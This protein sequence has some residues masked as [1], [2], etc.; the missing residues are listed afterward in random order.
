[1][2]FPIATTNAAQGTSY[3]QNA[4]VIVDTNGVASV[5]WSDGANAHLSYASPPYSTWQEDA[6]QNG[7]TSALSST[8]S[9]GGFIVRGAT[10]PSTGIVYD[11]YLNLAHHS[12]A[13]I[14]ASTSYTSATQTVLLF[15]DIQ[16][17]DWAVCTDPT[18]TSVEVYETTTPVTPNW[19]SSFSASGVYALTSPVAAICGNYLVVAYQTAAATFTSV[20]I[21]VSPSSL[22]SWS[23]PATFTLAAATASSTFC[24]RGNPSGKGMFVYSS[25]NG[26]AALT[27]D[28]VANTWGTETALSSNGNDTQP[29]LATVGSNFYAVWCRY[30]GANNYA[31]DFNL[32]RGA[33]Q[34][35]DIN[36][37]NLVPE[38]ANNQ[39]PQVGYGAN[40]IGV[41]YTVGTAAPYSVN[42][43]I[44]AA[45]GGL[46]PLSLYDISFASTTL[47]TAYTFATQTGGSVTGTTITSAPASG[48][49]LYMEALSQ[50]GTGTTNASIPAPS[51]KGWL[52]DAT[53][54]ENKN[55]PAGNWSASVTVENGSRSQ[56]LASM[57]IRFSV[58]SSAGA[59]TT[60]GTIAI[61][62][63]LVPHSLQ[64]FSFPA[65]AMP[66]TAFGIGDKL[67]VDYFYQSGTGT[68]AWASDAMAMAMSSLSSFGIANDLQIITPGYESDPPLTVYGSSVAATIITTADQLATTTGG[69]ETSTTTTAPASGAS[70]YME[71]LS[72]GGTGTTSATMPAQSG[73][74]WLLQTTTLDEQKMLAGNWSATVAVSDATR[75]LTLASMVLRFSKHF[76]TG[77]YATIGTITISS[78]ALTTSRQVFTFPSTAFLAS[79]FGIG[80]ML[81]IDFFYQSSGSAGWASDAMAI[82]LSTSATAGV[83]SDLQ[84]ATPGYIDPPGLTV[85]TNAISTSTSAVA[86]AIGNNTLATI[87]SDGTALT[88]WFDGTNQKYSY[89]SSPYSS[90][91]TNTLTTGARFAASLMPDGAGGNVAG[92]TCLTTGPITYFPLTKSGATYTLG[93]GTQVSSGTATFNPG[94]PMMVNKDPQ[95]RYWATCN[96]NADTVAQNFQSSTPTTANWTAGL[97]ATVGNDVFMPVA[98]IV[99]NYL[100]VAYWSSGTIFQYQ[101]LDVSQASLGSWST[102]TTIPNLGTTPTDDNTKQHAFRGNGS[103]VGQLIAASYSGIYAFGYTAATDT[104]ASGVQL[105]TSSS[106]LYPTIIGDGLGNLYCIWCLFS[107]TNS[108]SLVYKKWTGSTNTWDSSATTLIAA[109]TNIANPNAGWGNNGL[110]IL[111]TV[112]TATP[113]TVQFTRVTWATSGGGIVKSDPLQAGQA[114]GGVS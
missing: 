11:S 76:N 78:P 39:F 70:L 90:W 65:T 67:Y 102:A 66:K 97:A 53:V 38:G 71:A 54:L 24:L 47:S 16:N 15:R 42:F 57:T 106:D 81:Y 34:A 30:V 43:E 56:T 5:F 19:S 21:D 46:I 82:Y 85:S 112:G 68:N 28:P 73:K 8:V 45:D 7:E 29:T 14:F 23:A 48:A 60:I 62:N 36:A 1:M 107:A 111:S 101:R 113:W 3:P 6:Y 99:G 27:Y 98:D 18:G 89:A 114:T 35:W 74:G 104:W 52:Y 13:T 95:G 17:R 108:Y 25:S 69:T 22:G 51:G 55:I 20:R 88:T 100:V 12:H 37:I 33:S 64:T 58:R 32:W 91:T 10:V 75:S 40:I 96:T 2:S 84:V 93:S 4:T 92:V 110:G 79:T 41:A 72:R 109:G 86:T 31:I 80:D 9:T 94:Q 44:A 50:G 59:Y 61:A 49:S 26:I 87:A 77:G 105:S 83:A 103:G 63:Q